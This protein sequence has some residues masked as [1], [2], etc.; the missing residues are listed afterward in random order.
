MCI[1]KD[2]EEQDGNKRFFASKILNE[3]HHLI[4]PPPL[5]T[6]HKQQK[7]HL[8]KL[9]LIRSHLVGIV[10]ADEREGNRQDYPKEHVLLPE[11]YIKVKPTPRSYQFDTS[12]CL[13]ILTIDCESY[14]QLYGLLAG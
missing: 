12:S 10:S 1:K 14:I 9:T 13:T 5:F 6:K 11:L 3:S 4:A 2:I 8:L 7:W